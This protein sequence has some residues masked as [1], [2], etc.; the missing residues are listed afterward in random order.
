MFRKIKIFLIALILVVLPFTASSLV[1]VQVYQ[2]GTGASSLT[3]LILGNGTD[4]FTIASPFETDGTPN[5]SQTLLN[6]IA[7][8]QVT[9]TDDG[10]GGVTID[11]TAGT[12][13]QYTYNNSAWSMYAGKN[14]TTLVDTSGIGSLI[15]GNYTNPTSFSLSGTVLIGNNAGAN[16]NSSIYGTA[17]NTY[18]GGVA[19]FSDI[20]VGG[21]VGIGYGALYYNSGQNNTAVGLD[22]GVGGLAQIQNSNE[23]VYIGH[24]S[25]DNIQN[26][27]YDSIA[28]IFLGAQSGVNTSASSITGSIVLGSQT[29]ATNDFQFVLGGGI[30]GY[31]Q[32]TDGYFG[33]GVYMQPGYLANQF[34]M[35]A[36]GA[37]ITATDTAGADLNF[38]AGIGTGA[39]TSG[40]FGWY[41]SNPTTSG[42]TLQ[43]PTLKMVLS[44]DGQL[45]LNSYGSGTYTGTPTKA[46][47]VDASGTVIE[48]TL[49]SGGTVT[50]VD[51]SGGT[52]GLT[53]SGGPITTSG[54]LTLGGILVGANGGTGVANTGKT[55]TLGGNLETS[56]A[57]NV[58]FTTTGATNVTL[59]T[60][61]TLATLAGAESLTNK[62][63][64]SLTTNGFVKTSGGDGTLSVDTSTYI[65]GLTINTTPITSG[66]VGRVLFEGTGNVVQQS[67]NLFWDNTNNQLSLGDA[68]T[69]ALPAL[70]VGGTTNGI[71]LSTT[72]QLGFTTN[73]VNRMNLDATALSSV[74]NGGFWLRRNAGSATDP[75][76]TFKNDPDTGWYSDSANVLK[77]A[78]GGTQY[79]TINSTGVFIGGT[80]TPTAKL[81]LAAGSTSAS[82]AP[83]KFVSG[84][85]MTT[86]EAGAVEFTTD[87]LFFTITTGTARKRLLMADPASGIT[88]GQ[89]LYA[90]TNGRATGSTDMTFGSST[91]TVTKLKVGAGSV[92]LDAIDQ[93]QYNPSATNVANIDS[94]SVTAANWTRVGRMVHVW[95][96]FSVDPSSSG[97]LTQFTISLP[98]ASNLSSNYDLV[99]GATN[100]VDGETAGRIYADTG[101]DEALVEFTPRTTTSSYDWSYSYDY[102]I[103]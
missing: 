58:I 16:L 92:T 54:T 43:T 74:T 35:H 17:F 24:S 47:A 63:L 30:S 65:T 85:S 88:S 84:T 69:A 89:V 103:I 7:G 101:A 26:T 6:L 13:Y 31:N 72:N 102:E 3:G 14:I 36:T 1:P 15:T 46:L 99:G 45:S 21:N 8:S 79:G 53:V 77:W 60:T 64:G 66:T 52:T 44:N 67:A 50:S 2:G 19:G 98:I 42:T 90:T 94:V 4:P 62:K 70:A 12:D 61:G 56:G 10:V 20:G 28:N 39:A 75:T 51:G 91:L 78:N 87:D 38:S 93:A 96:I 82:S 25:G 59:P 27:N 97:V 11:I 9:L 34:T 23:A 57:N 76:Y 83:L 95:G 68:G 29:W 49:S 48:T 32:I 73:G 86:A 18:I 100:S 80:T 41:T 71:Y 40:R 33:G 37:D 81:H 22:A 5:G 55:I